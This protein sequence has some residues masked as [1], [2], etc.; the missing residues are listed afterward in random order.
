MLLLYEIYMLVAVEE[1]KH[2]LCQ[3]A[4]LTYFMMGDG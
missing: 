4:K 3:T 2:L 1:R